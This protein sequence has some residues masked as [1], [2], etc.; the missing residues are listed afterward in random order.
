MKKL[1]IALIVVLTL[2]LGLG[3]LTVVGMD[4]MYADVNT[5]Q[6]DGTTPD[7]GLVGASTVKI[8]PGQKLYILGWFA[9]HGKTVDK[10]VWT[11][12]RS[13]RAHV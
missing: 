3:V 11:L 7:S 1:T 4:A 9:E 6:W 2:V 8:D 5:L 13:E 10:V 12:D